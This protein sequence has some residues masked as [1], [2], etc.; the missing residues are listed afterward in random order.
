M[1]DFFKGL[2]GGMQTGLQFGQQLRQRRMED[3]LAAVYA[4][5]ETSPEN[6]RVG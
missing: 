6:G 2:A 5:P 4:K 1:A 3:E